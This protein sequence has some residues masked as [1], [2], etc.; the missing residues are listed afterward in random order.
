[1]LT[2]KSTDPPYMSYSVLVNKVFKSVTKFAR[3]KRTSTCLCN[4]TLV[5]QALLEE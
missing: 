1:M 2:V 4:Y 5:V 3:N